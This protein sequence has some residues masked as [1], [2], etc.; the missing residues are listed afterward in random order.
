MSCDRKT[1]MFIGEK[2]KE[3]EERG[4]AGEGNHE[5][6]SSHCRVPSYKH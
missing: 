6:A 3:M 4:E 2:N 1:K 5:R